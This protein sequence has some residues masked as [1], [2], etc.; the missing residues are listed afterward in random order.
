MR[1]LCRPSL[2][3]LFL[4]GA[5][6]CIGSPVS[7]H[8][9]CVAS[10]TQLQQALNAS[11]DGGVYAAEDNV[12]NIVKGHYLTGTASDNGPFHYNSLGT[13]RLYL[14]GGWATGCNEY[15]PTRSAILT[16]LDGGGAT[17]VLSVRNPSGLVYVDNLT[18]ENGEGGSPGAGLQI[19]YLSTVNAPVTINNV[20]VRNNHTTSSAGG[21]Y[22]SGSGGGNGVRLFGSLIYDN[23]A[24]NGYGAGYFTSYNNIGAALCSTVVRNTAASGI[25]GA[26][27]GGGSAWGIFSSI[28]WNNAVS[29]L[30]L[31]NA[32]V[33][34][35]YDDFGTRTG[36]SPHVDIG[37]LSVAPKFV[38]AAASNFHLAGD[39]PLLGVSRFQCG[40]SD[41][42]G[43]AFAYTGGQDLGAFSETIFIDNMDL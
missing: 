35:F 12:I 19:N 22:A 26:Y 30:E 4:A 11:S 9:F 16:R 33:D 1:T 14:T 8:E 6:S 20:I 24:D 15:D 43:K 28:F 2:P 3:A 25:G 29:G 31:G 23:S 5:L 17:A 13:H 21:V 36:N 41:V 42:E 40:G 39:S 37:S 34:L 27:F 38:D 7:A 18:V 10:S 32:S